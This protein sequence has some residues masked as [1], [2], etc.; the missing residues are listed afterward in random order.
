MRVAIHRPSELAPA[1]LER[2]RALARAQ[3]LDSPFLTPE[4]ALAVDS[5]WGSTRVAV[6]YD[7][8]D[9]VGFLPY[10]AGRFRTAT[11]IAD[12]FCNVQAYIGSGAP[13]TISEVIRAAP[14]DLLA[15]PQLLAKQGPPHGVVS[16]LPS[17]TIDLTAGYEAYLTTARAV[18]GKFV[19]EIV[20]KR[21]RLER[22]EE[23]VRFEFATRDPAA[24]SDLCAWKSAQYRRSGWRDML[25]RDGVREL[26]ERIAV[27]DGPGLQGCLTTLSLGDRLLSVGLCIRSER[28]LAGWLSA[29]DSAAARHSPGV[30]RWLHLIE[31][32]AAHGVQTIDLA[33]GDEEYKRRLANGSVALVS[34]HIGGPSVGLLA[35][36]IEHGP[37]ELARRVILAHPRLR[38]LTRSTLRHVGSLR[39]RHSS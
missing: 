14:I 11:P 34:C 22:E 5:V 27:E 20:R 25:A 15:F 28:V 17:L 32:A 26:V 18:S 38:G 12:D 29:Y 33:S 35:D 39:V 1:E 10:N 8:P 2:W 19:K 37:T 30:V 9:L 7:G 16:K 31:A 6:V 24:L 36:R 23:A 3:G 4:F 21:R 13:F